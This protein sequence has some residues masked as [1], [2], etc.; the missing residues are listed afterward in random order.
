VSGMCARL[1]KGDGLRGGIVGYPLAALYEEVAFV[2]Y[3][4]HWPVEAIVNLEH[5][6]RRKWIKEISGINERRNAQKN[7]DM[8]AESWP[9]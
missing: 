9:A 2:A 7:T 6:E 4:F 8:E 5:A 1:R 3:H